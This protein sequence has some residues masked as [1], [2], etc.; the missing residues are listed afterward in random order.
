[1]EGTPVATILSQLD[2][3]KNWIQYLLPGA[4]HKIVRCG[5]LM[6]FQ[7]LRP[8]EARYWTG[9]LSVSCARSLRRL[10]TPL[11]YT[12]RTC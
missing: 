8:G 6:M 3:A 1:M 2:D 10:N 7:S 9:Y 11:N 5:F 12:Y 4:W